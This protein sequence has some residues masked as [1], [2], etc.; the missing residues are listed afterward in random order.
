[1]KLWIDDVRV[2]PENWAWAMTSIDA[3]A[4]LD[5]LDIDE[6]SFDHDLGGSDTTRVVVLWLCE[7]TD[8]W[9]KINHVHSANP[10]GVEWLRGMINRYGPGVS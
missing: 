7:H 1:M 4:A 3:I 8:R 5:Q 6:V 10:V 9:P 2:P